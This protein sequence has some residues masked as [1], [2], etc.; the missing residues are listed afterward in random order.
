MSELDERTK[1]LY[2]LNE[3]RKEDLTESEILFV[4]NAAGLLPEEIGPQEGPF[5]DLHEAK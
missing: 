3:I 1:L 4:M 5:R 2:T